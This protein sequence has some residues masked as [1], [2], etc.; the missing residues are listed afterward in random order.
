MRRQNN[1]WVCVEELSSVN[2]A[3]DRSIPP[4]IDTDGIKNTVTVLLALVNNYWVCVEELSSVNSATDRSI[5]PRIDTDG[6]K[7]THN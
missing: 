2:S 7:N 5:P 4:R 1:Y 3:T 6:I